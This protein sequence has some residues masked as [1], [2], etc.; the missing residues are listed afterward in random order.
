MS[1]EEKRSFGANMLG[2]R[3]LFNTQKE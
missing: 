3:D 1:D 2:V